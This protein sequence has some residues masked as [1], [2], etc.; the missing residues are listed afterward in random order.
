MPKFRL[1]SITE[2]FEKKGVKTLTYYVI[3]IF[4]LYIGLYIYYIL[5]IANIHYLSSVFNSIT[6]RKCFDWAQE[7]Q[8]LWSC[9]GINRFH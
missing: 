7:S 3:D 4:V 6:T 9:P 1:H 8:L 2:T 5:Q